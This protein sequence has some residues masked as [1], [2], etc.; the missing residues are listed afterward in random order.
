MRADGTHRYAATTTSPDGT[1]SVE[2]T[3]LSDPDLLADLGLGPVEEPLLVRRALEQL[4]RSTQPRG[5]EPG[6]ALPPVI[7][8]AR[9]H[10]EDPDLLRNLTLR[11]AL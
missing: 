1:G 10:A 2:H 8:L 7:D 11:T 6:T 4:V 3:V 9:L 5:G